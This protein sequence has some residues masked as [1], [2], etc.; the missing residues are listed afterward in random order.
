MRIST[1]G[2]VY[3]G[4]TA[5]ELIIAWRSAACNNR[6]SGEGS[7]GPPAAIAAGILVSHS[8]RFQH[9]ELH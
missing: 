6:L 1:A 7:A 9:F 4:F 8:V 2:R 5:F 3:T